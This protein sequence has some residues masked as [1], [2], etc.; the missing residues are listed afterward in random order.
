MDIVA[1]IGIFIMV[2]AAFTW[3]IGKAVTE[4]AG[5]GTPWAWIVFGIGFAVTWISIIV[6]AL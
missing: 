1:W 5:W 4:D 2:A 3:F 6:S